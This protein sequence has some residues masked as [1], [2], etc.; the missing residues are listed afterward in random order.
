MSRWWNEAVGFLGDHT[1]G[2]LPMVA[3]LSLVITIMIALGWY[4]WPAWLPSRWR[5]RLGRA[6]SGDTER[7]GRRWRL[8]LG[9]L[10]WRWKWRRRKRATDAADTIAELPDDELPD[11]P[12][13]A[14]LLSADEL[15]AAGRYKESVRERLRAIVR[16]LIEREVIPASPG[17]TLTELAAFA[18]HSRPVLSPPLRRASDVFSEIWYGLRPARADDDAAVRAAADDVNA[19]L[20]EPLVATMVSPS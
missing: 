8:R 13:E 4:F 17:W 15:A 6:G 18:S 19:R 2:G 16:L 3:L 11:L 10:R 7:R 5:L 14:L 12:A 1:A 9:R 20:A